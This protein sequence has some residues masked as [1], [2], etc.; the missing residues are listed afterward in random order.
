M[1]GARP[2]GGDVT[3][4]GEPPHPSAGQSRSRPPAGPG[5]RGTEPPAAGVPGLSP[6]ADRRAALR[7][8][9][10]GEGEPLITITHLLRLC[11]DE[12]P[13]LWSRVDDPACCG[14]V[15]RLLRDLA[16]RLPAPGVATD[17]SPEVRAAFAAALEPVD[18]TPMVVVARALAEIIDDHYGHTFTASFA[19]RS[20]YQPQVGDPMPL[21]S[22]DLRR[23]SALPA[24]A[25]PWRLANRLDETRRAR[26]AGEWA[27][28]FRVVFDYALAGVLTGLVTSDTVVATC[29]PNTGLEELELPRDHRRRSFPI[30]PADPHRQRERLDSLLGAAVAQGASIVVLPELCV[31][32]ALARALEDWVRRP[33]G[34]RLL[35][36]GSYHHEDPPD[37]TTGHGP[38]RRRN[39]AMVWVRGWDR[40]LVHDKHSPA[41]RPVYEDLQPQG[42]PE[43]RVYVTA[44]GWH[45]VIAICRDLLNPRAVQALAE[46]GANLVLVPA[47]SETLV[48]FGGPVAQLVG[49]DQALVVVANNP[50]QWPAAGRT[51]AQRPARALVGHPGFGQLIRVVPAADSRPGI[52]RLQVRSGQLTWLPAPAPEAAAV[53]RPGGGREAA[54]PTW[55]GR[56]VEWS[57]PSSPD[58]APATT[59]TLRRAA[60]LVLVIDRP[61][62]PHVLLTRRT[63]DLADYPEQ[64]VFPGGATDAGDHGPV[65]TA[66][67]EAQE[68]TGLAP[69][70]VE[71]LGLLPPSALVDSGFLVTPVLA[72]ST[73]PAFP[74]AT[75]LAEVE[76]V[77]EVPLARR[78][79]G[80]DG[81]LAIADAPGYGRMTAGLLDLLRGMLFPAGEED[82]AEASLSRPP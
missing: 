76:S 47:M 9:V 50:A 8:A 36:A 68:E 12:H 26:L 20:P 66:L 35:V 40:P 14:R 58:I 25:P 7:A 19:R 5:A 33:D 2:T 42:W 48:P 67:R 27:A 54:A 73:A 45:L 21:D 55:V 74:G 38:G 71:V 22:P 41:D 15:D 52:A 3:K 43:L 62:G 72:W 57:R 78:G 77:T 61:E 69:A 79:S 29:H 32:E 59:V 53:A 10:A 75:N 11:R 4:R 65:D 37:P 30:R 46:A 81:G 28:Q 16:A 24:T 44:D 39:T 82:P 51:A 70:S 63:A 23:V 56:L 34:P 80:A 6:A 31:D 1:T 64:L 60:V 49:E 18:D 17:L 13:V